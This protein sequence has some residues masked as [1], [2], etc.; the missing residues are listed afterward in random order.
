MTQQWPGEGV[1][2]SV[3]AEVRQGVGLVTLNR[4]GRLNAWT[5]ELGT[6]YFDILDR[7]AADPEVRVILVTGAG[8]RAFSAGADMAGM[9]AV[10]SDGAITDGRDPRRYWHPMRIGKPVVAALRG[11]CLG[12]GFQQAISCDIRIAASDLKMS[13]S[14]VRR[15]MNGELGIT[16]LL[17]RLVGA[18]P[19]MELMLSGRTIDATEALAL[20]LVSRVVAPDD[21]AQVAFAY[22]RD[23]AQ[24]CSPW[25]MRTMK[26]QLWLDLMSHLPAAYDR[27]EDQLAEAMASGDFA[28]SVA[29]F[30]A[31]R[32]PA[33]PPLDGSLSHLDPWPAG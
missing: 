15:G 22:C 7:L 14:Y 12:V 23:L 24:N 26:Q 21:L 17:P 10:A 31:K 32:P 27:S 8:E 4:P 3:L 33:F 19:A 11:Y 18:G 30:G 29:A 28:E 2:P 9:G 20:R 13:T 16:W 6:L 5:P 1:A 25:S